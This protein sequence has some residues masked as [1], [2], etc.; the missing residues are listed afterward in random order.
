MRGRAVRIEVASTQAALAE[1]AAAFHQAP[2]GSMRV[3]A[4]A[5][6]NGAWKTSFLLKQILQRTGISIGLISSV[7]HEI[8]ERRLPA[9]QTFESDFRGRNRMEACDAHRLLAEMTRADCTGC[10]VEAG[11]ISIPA[12]RSIDPDTF[13]F[14]SG[15]FTPP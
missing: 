4:V 9:G 8:G 7:R 10:V 13:I 2:V 14:D 15:D 11:A 1:A 12:L 5:G 3:A 6:K